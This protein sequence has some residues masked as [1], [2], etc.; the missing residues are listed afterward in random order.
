MGR[1]CLDD[2]M[3]LVSP[4]KAPAAVCVNQRAI[5]DEAGEG[6]FP[7]ARPAADR[8]AGVR[9]EGVLERPLA[10][11]GVEA[12]LGEVHAGTRAHPAP[13][14]STRGSGALATELL[15]ARDHGLRVLYPHHEHLSELLAHATLVLVADE[16]PSGSFDVVRGWVTEREVLVA[17]GEVLD[18]EA[19][20][21]LVR[22]L[23][24][25]V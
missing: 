3:R 1:A 9:R 21:A 6:R 22:R 11:A 20:L 5:G 18:Q 10:S 8:D 17:L 24:H 19:L 23:P 25:L 15:G 4:R 13:V 2:G 16:E 7:D 12:V 14:H